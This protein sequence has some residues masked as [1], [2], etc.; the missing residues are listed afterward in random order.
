MLPA[1]T[2]HSLGQDRRRQIFLILVSL[3]ILL[4]VAN[5]Y[6]LSEAVH[7]AAGRGGAEEEFSSI[8]AKVSALESEYLQ[9]SKM[10]TMEEAENRGLVVSTPTIVYT[11]GRLTLGSR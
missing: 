7:S 9:L 11:G 2:I 5:F 3:L 6:F 8:N 4:G 10:L 1:L